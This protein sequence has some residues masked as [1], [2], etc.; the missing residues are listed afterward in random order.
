[1]RQLEPEQREALLE[2]QEAEQELTQAEQA[3]SPIPMVNQSRT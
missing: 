1:V 2:R 3:L